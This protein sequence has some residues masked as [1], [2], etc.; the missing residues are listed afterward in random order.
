M[1]NLRVAASSAALL[2]AVFLCPHVNAADAD[3]EPVATGNFTGRY[4]DGAAV[5]RLPTVTV[6]VSR[7]A[8]LAKI[9][10]EQRDPRSRAR[11]ALNQPRK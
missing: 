6:A 5:Y 10:Q 9:E 11:L 3:R 8:E 7:K 4:V 1:S 2:A